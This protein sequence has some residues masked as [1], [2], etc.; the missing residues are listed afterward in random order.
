MTAQIDTVGQDAHATPL[1]ATRR[2]A[3]IPPLD[4]E[5]M[6]FDFDTSALVPGQY[7]LHVRASADDN[8]VVAVRSVPFAVVPPPP[9]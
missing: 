2:V 9:R 6:A 8:G 3:V 7:L 4:R 5:E 1:A